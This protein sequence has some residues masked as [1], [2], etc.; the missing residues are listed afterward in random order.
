MKL[1]NGL[2]QGH[3]YSITGLE[4]VSYLNDVKL[5]VIFFYVIYT[6]MTLVII[7]TKLSINHAAG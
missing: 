7:I 5:S 3:A 1:S 2:L 4:E 6:C